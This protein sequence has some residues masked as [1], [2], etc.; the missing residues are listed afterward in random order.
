MI[1]EK[2]LGG[3]VRKQVY[4]EP[5]IWATLQQVADRRKSSMLEYMRD[6]MWDRYY[7]EMKEFPDLN[8]HITRNEN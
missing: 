6:L 8:I 2:F 5:G 1:K 3:K 7:A 4:I